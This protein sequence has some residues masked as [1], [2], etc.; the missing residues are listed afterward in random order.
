MLFR[1][2]EINVYLATGQ[3]PERVQTNVLPSA[4]AASVTT[5]CTAPSF[6]GN[7]TVT[8]QS[9]QMPPIVAAQTP[10]AAIDPSAAYTSPA[11]PPVQGVPAGN[12]APVRNFTGFSF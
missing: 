10:P 11:Q 9:V 4:P 2:D 6:V 5:T 1:S 3:F 7:T 8:P 12:S